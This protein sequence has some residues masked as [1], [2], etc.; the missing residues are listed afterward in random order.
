[1]T[2]RRAPSRADSAVLLISVIALALAFAP[3][4]WG[5]ALA[6]R[7]FVFSSF[8]Y[9]YDDCF[10]YLAK[11]R[12]GYEGRWL[13]SNLYTTEPHR[14]AALFE[15][16]LALGHLC[17]LTGLGLTL[18]YHLARLA[19]AIA[20]LACW[21]RLLRLWDFA[22]RERVMAFFIGVFGGGIGWLYWATSYDTNPMEFWLHEAHG[23]SQILVFAHFAWSGALM[24]TGLAGLTKLFAAP[25][26]S[27]WALAR[28]G[29]AMFLMTWIHPRLVLNIAA[30]GGAAAALGAAWG[31]WPLRRAVVP[32]AT[33]LAGSGVVMAV[34]V[35]SY[36]GDPVWEAWASTPLPR[37]TAMEFLGLFGL[38]W[39]LGGWGLVYAWR[40]RAPWGAF[41]VAWAVVGAILPWL[42]IASARRLMQGYGFA[43]GALSAVALVRGPGRRL[44][45]R[46]GR[47]ASDSLFVAAA[48]ALAV[49]PALHWGLGFRDLFGQRFPWFIA[50]ERLRAMDWLR[51]HGDAE[52]VVLCAPDSGLLTP[53]YSGRRVVIG[54]WAET[55][56]ARHKFEE[57]NWPFFKAEM[58]PAERA[59]MLDRRRVTILLMTSAERRLG[60][61]KGGPGPYDPETMDPGQWTL[62]WV[63][64]GIFIY[65]R[66]GS[67]PGDLP[68]GD[69]NS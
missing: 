63:G 37:P 68:P 62:V 29:L 21:D 45:V 59:A 10:T 26:V 47:R 57:E 54:H 31:I 67:A 46:F 4:L 51:V 28:L 38:L 65:R 16:Y 48:L 36:R 53:A 34:T 27:G 66:T 14:P 2:P 20:L 64:D 24:L 17:R 33:A 69:P 50:Q 19:G 44:E 8:V 40:S 18:M 52:D 32:L 1:M 61:V 41:L 55:L 58:S 30:I 25:R 9:V 60:S 22:G 11:M 12:T 13:Y 43:L 6:P 5:R 49:T 42:P 56:D 39:P 15:F 7:G 3:A 35:L 23:F